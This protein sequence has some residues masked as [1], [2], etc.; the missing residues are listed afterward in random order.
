MNYHFLNKNFFLFFLVRVPLYDKNKEKRF[1]SHQYMTI[2]TPIQ[3]RDNVS[4]KLPELESGESADR[5]GT[6]FSDSP[7]KNSL[8]AY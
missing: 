7:C 4:K 1:F 2:H 6:N 8:L 5:L 3:L